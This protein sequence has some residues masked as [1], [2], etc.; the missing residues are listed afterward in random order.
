MPTQETFWPKVTKT[1][2]CWVWSAAKDPNGYGRVW[3]SRIGNMILA[4]MAS[5]LFAF[6]DPGSLFVCHACDNPSCVR[7]DHLFLGTAADNATDREK[8]GRTARGLDLPQGRQTHCRKA[9]HPL[10][11]DNLYIYIGARNC[12]RCHADRETI[13][14][15]KRK[16]ARLA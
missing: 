14:R 11:G 15:E 6:G 1:E 5:Y 13:R 4:H 2:S 9:G 8:K 10:S 7:P 3:D 12:R 16:A